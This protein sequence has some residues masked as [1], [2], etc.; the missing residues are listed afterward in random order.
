[1]I[2]IGK[3][4]NRGN[5][6]SIGQSHRRAQGLWGRDRSISEETGMRLKQNKKVMIAL[7]IGFKNMYVWKAMFFSPFCALTQ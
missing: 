7:K 6:A 5:R 1:M 3:K 2:L 4:E